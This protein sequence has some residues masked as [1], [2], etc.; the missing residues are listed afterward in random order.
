MNN[1]FHKVI[2]KVMESKEIDPKTEKRIVYF[3]AF[4]IFVFVTGTL[5]FSYSGYTQGIKERAS[6]YLSVNES[7]ITR[8]KDGGSSYIFGIQDSKGVI[9]TVEISK[10]RLANEN[11]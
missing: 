8:I 3:T 5:L 7:Q 6:K 10:E 4:L 9:T 1:Y 11:K 2:N